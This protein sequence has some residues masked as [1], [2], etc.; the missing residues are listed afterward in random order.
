LDTTLPDF[1]FLHWAN[2]TAVL[3]SKNTVLAIQHYTI[4]DSFID[5]HRLQITLIC[6]RSS[7]AH[8]Q[9]L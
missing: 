8:S 5:R 4:I 2:P 6:F 7:W 3:I 9:F 1:Y